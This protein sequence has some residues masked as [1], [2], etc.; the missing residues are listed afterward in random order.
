MHALTL[1]N[2]ISFLLLPM[3]T[4]QRALPAYLLKAQHQILLEIDHLSY[5]VGSKAER[6]AR[7]RALQNPLPSPSSSTSRRP[8]PPVDEPTLQKP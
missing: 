2:S 8:R 7:G 1:A 6:G 5:L 4:D 3:Q